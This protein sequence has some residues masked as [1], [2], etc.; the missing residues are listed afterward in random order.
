MKPLRA[1]REGKRDGDPDLSI[2]K[3]NAIYVAIA[4][5]DLP[6]INSVQMCIFVSINFCLVVVVVGVRND[7][8]AP[9]YLVSGIEND[10]FG[11][12]GRELGR[13]REVD[14]AHCPSSN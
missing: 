3:T 7:F 5:R 14:V 12:D 9:D 6:A 10:T 13:V 8:A 11:I 2:V 1:G 4:R